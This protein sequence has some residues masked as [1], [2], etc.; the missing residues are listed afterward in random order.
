MLAIAQMWITVAI[1]VVKAFFLSH[2]CGCIHFV[3]SMKFIYLPSLPVFVPYRFCCW[4][5]YP[6]VISRSFHAVES[7]CVLNK[8]K[9]ELITNILIILLLSNSFHGLGLFVLLSVGFHGFTL[10]KSFKRLDK[11]VVNSNNNIILPTTALN[12]LIS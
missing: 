10:C 5:V 1:F 4:K 7:N 6:E 3:W 8:L 11:L 9:P 12:F 2:V